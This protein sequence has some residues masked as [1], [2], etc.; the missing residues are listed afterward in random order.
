MARRTDDAPTRESRSRVRTPSACR[1]RRW[2]SRV[3]LSA[4]I[5]RLSKSRGPCPHKP[6][7]PPA[8]SGAGGAIAHPLRIGRLQGAYGPGSHPLTCTMLP[9]RPA[10]HR[11]LP[12]APCMLQPRRG[13]AGHTSP[14]SGRRDASSA[15]AARLTANKR[16]AVI[17]HFTPI[18]VRGPLGSQSK[19][20]RHRGR[21]QRGIEPHAASAGQVE[22]TG[23]RAE[24]LRDATPGQAAAT[25]I[26]GPRSR[27][28]PDRCTGFR[29]E[30]RDL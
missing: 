19:K 26:N 23:V 14:A 29:G 8:R 15:R 7:A 2:C 20:S 25:L 13:A 24:D 18:Q 5:R 9:F 22:T 11:S 4:C 12:A 30:V 1:P 3:L 27:K 10:T 17:F 16:V 6:I 21:R 28:P